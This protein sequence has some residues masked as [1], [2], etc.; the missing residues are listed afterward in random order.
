M[1]DQQSESGTIQAT[2]PA[3]APTIRRLT[4]ARFRGI[5]S[6][7]WRPGSGVNLILGGG[8]VGKSTIL[9]AIGLLLSPVNLSTLSDTDYFRRGVADGFEIEA[10]MALPLDSAI[11]DQMRPSWPWAWDGK[12]AVVPAL[13]GETGDPAYR[14]RVRGTEDLEL[15]YEVLQ[16]DG[17]TDSLSVTLRRSIGLVRLSGDDRNDRDLR[18][19][20][21]SAL[22]RLL[23]D[24][25]L[26]SRLAS[27]LAKSDV[28]GELAAPAQKA[29][30]ELDTAF[31]ARNLPAG[32]DLAITGSQGASIAALIGLT[33]DC[34]GVPLPLAS[35]GAGTRRLAA[36][37]IAEQR[38]GDRPVT[39]V[40]E[41][42]RGLEPYRQRALIE[43]LQAGGAQVFI[44]THSPAAIAATS[45]A[46]LWYVDHKGEIGA[47]AA[48]KV[49]RHRV[50]D[51]DAFLSR[52]TI[53]AEGATE[54]GF[55]SALLERA[56]GNPLIHFGV[57]VSNGG[58]HEFTL[59]LLE[60][61]KAGGLSFGGFADDEDGKHPTRWK[62]LGDALGRLLFR[63][64]KGCLE[65]NVFAVA[66]DAT[67][68]SLMADPNG[69]RTG[70]RRQTLTLRL[71]IQAKTFAEVAA[72]AGDKLRPTMIE[73]TLGTVPDGREEDKATY[74]AHGSIWFKS[75]A[76]GRELADKVFDL[77]LWP[78]LKPQLLPFCNGV[79]TALG[80][81]EIEDLRA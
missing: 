23:S 57:H 15:V 42:E 10:V 13:D 40:D 64:P 54:V 39:L 46:S 78:A 75:V 48:T 9:D 4:I 34:E 63:W 1:T 24:K 2:A 37:A 69:E 35:W 20:Q 33:A 22:D 27:E 68:E 77:G 49:A 16:P 30:G 18:L 73:A 11:V 17:S 51:P 61:L 70:I 44:T 8:D 47:L 7:I 26:R 81:S 76:G 12:D 41:V 66:P 32:L 55:S 21:G 5:S 3:H 60:G 50:A 14:L 43:K 36:L 67:L 25:G 38:Q 45:Q 80:L 71:G 6:L 53:V 72:A 65:E 74:K 59:E 58:G 52:L 19:V 56:L 79:R 29:L 28:K 62:T 31:R